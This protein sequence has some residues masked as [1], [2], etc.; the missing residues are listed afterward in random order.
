MGKDF[1]PLEITLTLDEDKI[2]LENI[3]TRQKRTLTICIVILVMVLLLNSL[4][5]ISRDTVT[6]IEQVGLV[7]L[8]DAKSDPSTIPDFDPN[9]IIPPDDDRVQKLNEKLDMGKMCINMISKVTFKDTYASGYVNIV[10]DDANNYPQFVTI[11][12]DSNGMQLY[13]SG[14]IEV[15]KTIPYAMLEVEL[16]A[17]EY[18]CTAVFSQVD[19]TEDKVCGQAAAKVLIVVQN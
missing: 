1:K 7:S 9:A 14:L 11:T 2:A 10:N 5:I 8:I 18:E 12:L 13:Q 3:I 17:G 6:K 15:G 19:T 16:P 4:V